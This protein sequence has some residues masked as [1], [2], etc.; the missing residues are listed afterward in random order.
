MVQFDAIFFYYE[1]LASFF[2][3][4]VGSEGHGDGGVSHTVEAGI[5]DHQH[6]LGGL[7]QGLACPQL[8]D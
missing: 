2:G 5:Y 6:R 7:S 4:V 1:Q 8:T 3:L